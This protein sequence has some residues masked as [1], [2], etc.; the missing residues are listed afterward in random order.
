MNTIQEKGLADPRSVDDLCQNPR[1]ASRSEP[2]LARSENYGITAKSVTNASRS[3][4]G[5]EE[6]ISF[7]QC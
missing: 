4:I 5:R 7:T 3:N 2:I 1:F 6:C